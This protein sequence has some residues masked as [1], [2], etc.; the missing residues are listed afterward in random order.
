[1]PPQDADMPGAVPPELLRAIPRP[2]RLTVA[3]KLAAVV[4]LLLAIGAPAA[5]IGLYLAHESGRARLER[6]RREVAW[7]EAEVIQTG[8]TRDKERRRFVVYRYAAGGRFYTGRFTVRRRDVVGIGVGSR[9]T[10]GYLPSEPARSWRVGQEPAG[11]PLWVALAVAAT[12]AVCAAAITLVLRGQRRL[13]AEG[14]AAMGSVKASQRIHRRGPVYRVHY[15]FRLLSGAVRSG[16]FESRKAVA[17]G[18]PVV[19]IYDPDNPRRQGRYPFSLV[20]VAA[21][22]EW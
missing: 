4:A 6:I 21:P 10:V 2:V 9:L 12:L 18:S 3:G 11:P 19:V 8:T 16:S 15:E 13:L 5:G 14:R 7:T 20:R 22:G 17:P 1:M